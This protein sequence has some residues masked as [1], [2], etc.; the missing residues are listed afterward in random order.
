MNHDAEDHE[1]TQ[2]CPDCK[3]ESKSDMEAADRRLKEW[4]IPHRTPYYGECILC[5][6]SDIR[7]LLH[8]I[9]EQLL[10]SAGQ[11]G[12]IT[13]QTDPEPVPV[14]PVVEGDPSVA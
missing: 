10:I 1:P 2:F 3:A 11:G 7:S 6:T 12:V 4:C 9:F 5:I 8:D 14:P 13:S